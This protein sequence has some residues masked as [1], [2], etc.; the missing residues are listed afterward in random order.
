MMEE[1]EE[2]YGILIDIGRKDKELKDES[3]EEK[4]NG[5]KEEELKDE[6]EEDEQEKEEIH[7]SEFF[8]MQTHLFHSRNSH[9]GNDK[10]QERCLVSIIFVDDMDDPDN[11]NLT[12]TTTTLLPDAVGKLCQESNF[13]KDLIK[14]IG[15]RNERE[16]AT[17]KNFRHPKNVEELTIVETNPKAALDFLIEIVRGSADKL[18]AWDKEWVTWIFSLYMT[19][20]FSLA[21]SLS[22]FLS[23]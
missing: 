21:F 1:K 11:N 5:G 4:E 17:Y 8:A 3:K 23:L 19:D 18:S 12:Q 16:N 2:E 15:Y 7:F 20:F 22:D 9:A 6:K 10:S 13:F 14:G